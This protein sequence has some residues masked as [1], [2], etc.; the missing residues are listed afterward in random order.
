[1]AKRIGGAWGNALGGYRLQ[2]RV[3]GKF[4]SGFAGKSSKALSKT[5]TP[6]N[7]RQRRAQYLEGKRKE[8]VRKKRNSNI[9]KVAAGAIVVGAVGAAGYAAHR[10]GN[11]SLHSDSGVKGATIRRRGKS[12]NI[13]VDYSQ[14]KFGELGIA[15]SAGSRDF[16]KVVKGPAV[17]TIRSEMKANRAAQKAAKARGVGGPTALQKVKAKGRVYS[18]DLVKGSTGAATVVGSALTIQKSIKEMTAPQHVDEHGLGKR[19]EGNPRH[20]AQS[21]SLAH[22]YVQRAPA[23]SPTNEFRPNNNRV[24]T[25]H[26]PI[27]ERDAAFNSNRVKNSAGGV[28]PINWSGEKADESSYDNG[29]PFDTR[30]SNT[31][32]GRKIAQEIDAIRV[33]DNAMVRRVQHD[34]GRKVTMSAAEVRG[35]SPQGKRHSVKSG[36]RYA[37]VVDFKPDSKIITIDTTQLKGDQDAISRAMEVNQM[38]VN[39]Q[40]LYAKRRMERGAA[41]RARK[42][43]AAG[44]PK[45]ARKHQKRHTK[46]T[47]ADRRAMRLRKKSAAMGKEPYKGYYANLSAQE[48]RSLSRNSGQ[49]RYG[50]VPG[51]VH[52]QAGKGATHKPLLSSAKSPM[53]RDAV[54][55]WEKVLEQSGNGLIRG[56]E[57]MSMTQ[58]AGNLRVVPVGHGEED[59]WKVKKHKDDWH[60]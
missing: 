39:P 56:Y 20:L 38:Y 1:M 6:A 43:R 33:G 34:T 36:S 9:R 32:H 24:V 5:K 45:A 23:G 22:G 3:G 59:L 10:N 52:L 55:M 12:A 48:A 46:M 26:E 40:E 37:G 50:I 29:D 51:D 47:E 21:R 13:G 11:L 17:A 35:G 7:S 49:Y 58:A 19:A 15:G 25:P 18:D 41:E 53:S 14:A 60:G 42:A 57:D 54:Q 44:N 30:A 28:K 2:N 16:E 31:A 4:S 8:A 27:S